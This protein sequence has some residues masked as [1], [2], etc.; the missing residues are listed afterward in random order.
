MNRLLVAAVVLLVALG[1]LLGSS[2]TSSADSPVGKIYYVEAGTIQRSNLDGSA[3]EE[4]VPAGHSPGDM[5][6]DKT[7]VFIYWINAA[8]GKIQRADSDGSNIVDIVTGVSGLFRLTLDGTGMLYWITRNAGEWFADGTIWRANVDG[9]NIEAILTDGALHSIAVDPIQG[10]IYWTSVNTIF[11]SPLD[12]STMEDWSKVFK[13]SGEDL[14][15]DGSTGDVYYAAWTPPI[16]TAGFPSG[17]VGKAGGWSRII[18]E[19]GFHYIALDIEHSHVYW[20]DSSQQQ[21]FRANLDGTDVFAV[22]DAGCC[23]GGIALGP[24][25]TGESCPPPPARPTTPTPTITPTPTATLPLGVGGVA[26]G[27]GLAPLRDD[28]EREIRGVFAIAG[29]VTVAF[30]LLGSAWYARKRWASR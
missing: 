22:L 10:Y 19:T 4:V 1:T 21:L 30:A 16:G 27:L 29:V 13:F 7:G 26:L 28:G 8:G 15:L 23:S 5:A 24:C 9:S 25:P 17:T 2:G 14:A 18:A 11:R 12:G 20:T 3:E 6:I